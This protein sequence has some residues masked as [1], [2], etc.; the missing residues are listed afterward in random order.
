MLIRKSSDILSS[1]ITPRA[2]YE[3][4][5]ANRRQFLAG[6]GAV[7]AAALAAGV[8]EERAH[9]ATPGLTKLTTVPSNYKV[10]E[11]VTPEAK[12][13]SYNNFYEFGTDKSEPAHNAHTLRTR[14]WTI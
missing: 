6:L 8:F 3:A 1:E 13:Q 4:F 10:S 9:A 12:A 2:V 7:G 11:T 5:Q 14:P